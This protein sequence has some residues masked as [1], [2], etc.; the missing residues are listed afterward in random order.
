MKYINRKDV[1]Y[2]ENKGDILTSKYYH[3]FFYPDGADAIGDCC[4]ENIDNKNWDV[5]HISYETKDAY[6]GTPMLG[7]CLI[8]CMILKE[9]TRD[10]LE[11]ELNY[12]VGMVGSHFGNMIR[13][14]NIEIEPVIN[15]L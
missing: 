5:F 1:E 11:S 13:D 8:D 9:D 2:V 3:K 4:S 10:F 7:M 6:Y 14:Y 12:K 15:R